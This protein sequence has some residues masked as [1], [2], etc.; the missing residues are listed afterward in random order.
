MAAHNSKITVYDT[1][2]NEIAGEFNCGK[3]IFQIFPSKKSKKLTSREVGIIY[4]DG[5]F[6]VLSQ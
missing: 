4:E 1:L 2:R 3:R 5:S 6:A